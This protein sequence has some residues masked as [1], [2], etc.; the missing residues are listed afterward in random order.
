[1][2]FALLANHHGDQI[3][4]RQRSTSSRQREFK[5]GDDLCSNLEYER[6]VVTVTIKIPIRRLDDDASMHW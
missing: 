3:V 2:T 4:F 1:M 6:R 5:Y